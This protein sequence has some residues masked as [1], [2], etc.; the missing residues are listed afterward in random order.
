MTEP[1]LRVHHLTYRYPDDRLALD[2]I[3]LEVHPGEKVALVGPNGAGKSTLL[4][5][6]NGVLGARDQRQGAT[7]VTVCGLPVHRKTLPAVRASVGLVFQDPD[8]QLFSTTVFGDVAYGPL[9]M[10]CPI[11]EIGERV[12]A[13][14][15]QVGLQGF[16]E[17]MPHH[18][19]LGE[20]K[21]VAMATVLS[22]PVEILALDEPTAGMDPRARRDLTALLRNLP[23]TMLVA[24][25]DMRLV[26]ELCTRTV[27]LDAGRVVADG[28]TEVLLRDESLLDAHGLETPFWL[29]SSPAQSHEI[30]IPYTPV[31]PDRVAS[32]PTF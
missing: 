1:A 18:L 19:S 14:L 16:E 21:R 9:N 7:A 23:Q 25:H 3:S 10:G 28:P 17:R 13:A 4:L 6:L 31:G 15:A 24:T 8:D 2:S 5:H 12:R 30:H 22:M 20:R 11:A 27:I 26:W 32:V 29:P